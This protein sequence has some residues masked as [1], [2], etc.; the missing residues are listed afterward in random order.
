MYTVVQLVGIEARLEVLF[1]PQE[2][3]RN[4]EEIFEDFV[5]AGHDFARSD[6]I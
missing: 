5:G 3:K 2:Q 6:I 4:C 1:Q